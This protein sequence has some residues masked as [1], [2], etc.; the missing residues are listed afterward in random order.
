MEFSRGNGSDSNNNNDNNNN[1]GQN[2]IEGQISGMP[3]II[4][5]ITIIIGLL[6]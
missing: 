6:A 5:M 3:I 2:F 1:E 4:S